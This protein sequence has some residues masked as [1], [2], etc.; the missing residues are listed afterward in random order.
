M[1][2]KLNTD[3]NHPAK[4][5][6]LVIVGQK[7]LRSGLVTLLKSLPQ[8]GHI[9]FS[10][11]VHDAEAIIESHPIRLAILD[12]EHL[13]N[14]L[15]QLLAQLKSKRVNV[16]TLGDWDGGNEE[17]LESANY[18]MKGVRPKKLMTEIQKKCRQL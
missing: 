13:D 14:N 9:Y 15:P 17:D 12:H 1:Q 4:C 7:D 11:T 2:A 8:V 5:S 6:V 3:Q 16:I 10:D 18:V